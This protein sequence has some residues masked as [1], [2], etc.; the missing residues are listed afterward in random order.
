MRIF[1]LISTILWQRREDSLQ[2]GQGRSLEFRR[3][4]KG[5]HNSD[6]SRFFIKFKPELDLWLVESLGFPQASINL[7]GRAPVF[8]D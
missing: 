2:F 5:N 1:S 8:E 7:N 3:D 4:I 6:E